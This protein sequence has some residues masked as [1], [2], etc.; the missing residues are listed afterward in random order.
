M[1]VSNTS[2]NSGEW[3]C[4]HLMSEP[5][6]GVYFRCHTSHPEEVFGSS[7]ALHFLG[8]TQ[9]SLVCGHAQPCC[10]PGLIGRDDLPRGIPEVWSFS[11]SAP[12]SWV[13]VWRALS[14]YAYFV[15]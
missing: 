4:R 9:R 2:A 11:L 15:A 12:I 3:Q 10:L 13:S 1:Q 7:A 6:L 8:A 14:C 5:G